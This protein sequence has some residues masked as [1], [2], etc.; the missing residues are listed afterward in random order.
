[1]L[2]SPETTAACAQL[3]GEAQRLQERLGATEAEL[4][5]HRRTASEATREAAERA[6]AE[7][8]AVLQAVSER[9][10]RWCFRG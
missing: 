2:A 6:A 1:V 4:R 8:T 10:G 5:H 7:A 3:Q 9:E